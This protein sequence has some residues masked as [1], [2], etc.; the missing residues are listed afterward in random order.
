[1][2]TFGATVG[3]GVLIQ[4]KLQIFKHVAVETATTTEPFPVGVDPQNKTI[5]ENPAV[6]AFFYNTLAHTSESPS[7]W[8]RVAVLFFEKNWYQNLASPV[9]R[10]VVIWPGERTEEV[11]KHFGDILNWSVEERDEF[12]S[13]VQTSAPV[14]QEGKFFPSEYVTHKDARPDEM[15]ILVTSKFN[16]EIQARYTSDVA[17]EVPL[18]DALVIASLLEREARDFTNMREISGVI[19]N[20]LFLDMPLQLDATLQ[21]ARGSRPLEPK[22]W[23]VVRPSDKYINSPFN[24]YQNEG[25]PPTPI[26]NPSSEAVLAA[27]NPRHTDCLYYF[28]DNA[29]NYYCSPT[30]EEHIAKLRQLY[31]RGR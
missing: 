27:L 16:T 2:L 15:A 1:M 28:H 26:A 10:V 9:S 24:T 12:V 4:S 7:W 23:P 3:I 6:D 11:K 25:L 5:V 19:W 30:Y 20:R 17:A 18:D 8:Q 31:G 29:Q 14:L 21:Y 13:L 22:W